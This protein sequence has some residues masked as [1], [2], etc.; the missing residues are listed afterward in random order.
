V[1]ELLLEILLDQQE[2]PRREWRLAG[3]FAL[4]GLDTAAIAI[5]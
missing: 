5:V 2:G 3:H 1:F 4:K